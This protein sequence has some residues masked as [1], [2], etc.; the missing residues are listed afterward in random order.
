MAVPPPQFD[1]S[2][3]M[4]SRAI[5]ATSGRVSPRLDDETDAIEPDEQP[6]SR[7]REVLLAAYVADKAVYEV[8]YEKRNRP[9]WTGIPLA[10]LARVGEAPGP[11][12]RL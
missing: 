5:S 8:V 3:R 4:R 12:R 9:G 2:S 6:S 1:V 7:E 10:A 11:I